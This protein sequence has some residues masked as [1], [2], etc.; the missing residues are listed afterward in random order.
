MVNPFMPYENE[1]AARIRLP[2]IFNPKTFRRTAGGKAVLPGAGLIT[3]PKTIG[4]VWGKITG[5]DKEKDE[6]LVQSLRFNIKDWSEAQ[7]KKWLKDNKVNYLKFEKAKNTKAMTEK[8]ILLYTS[9]WGNTAELFIEKFGE[10]PSDEN[11]KVRLN[12]PGGS[13]FAGWGMITKMKEHKG[14]V[15]IQVDGHAASMGMFM[16]LFAD[17]VEAIKQ[18]QIMIHRANGYVENDDDKKLLDNVN[19]DIRKALEARIDEKKLEEITGATLD[20]IFNDEKRRDIW[21]TADEAKKIGLVDKVTRIEPKVL[22]ALNNKLVAFTD[23]T[24]LPLH[25]SDDEPG[26]KSHVSETVESDENKNNN[27]QKFK[28]MTKQELKNQHPE[29]YAEIFNEGKDDG[30]KAEAIRVKAFLAFLKFDN[31]GVI[32]AIKEGTD[33]STDVQAELMAKMTGK[34]EKEKIENDNPEN[35]DTDDKAK[36]EADLKKEAI[37]A[38]AADVIKLI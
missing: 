35:L 9:I 7:A 31:E 34:V 22:D 8:E 28:K 4:I 19:K 36:T 5:R 33:F 27:N 30:A 26:D 6:P 16:L 38:E 37:D 20:N 12:C 3:V 21:L 15:T 17:K 13:V 11:V 1:H 25:V 23:Y 14:Q 24:D 29:L 10:I 18:A 2:G 32:K